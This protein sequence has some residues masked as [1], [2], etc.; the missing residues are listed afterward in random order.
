MIKAFVTE[1]LDLSDGWAKSELV[2]QCVV[3]LRAAY[4]D[5]L[6]AAAQIHHELWS[7]ALGPFALEGGDRDRG[8]PQPLTNAFT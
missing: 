4:A 2:H 5:A 6:S 8:K 1:F 3:P 7:C